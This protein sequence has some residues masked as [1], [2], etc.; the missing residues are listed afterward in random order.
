LKGAKEAIKTVS[1][2]INTADRDSIL[3]NLL[4]PTLYKAISDSLSSLPDSN[5][6]HLHLDKVKD[7]RLVSINSIT[8][9]VPDPDDRH[10]VAW[11]GQ[12]I[13]ASK[14]KLD[15]IVSS[16]NQF[17]VYTAKE[18]GK[19]AA[20]TK[21]LFILSVSFKAKEKFVITETETGNIVQG[22]DQ[23][24]NV[25]H[26]WQFGSEVSHHESYPF[27]WRVYDINRYLEST[28]PSFYY[29]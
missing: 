18:L 23:Y 11:L 17:T 9:T 4:H 16:N 26:I 8:G 21:I 19:E 15:N 6:I 14:T 20:L 22:V 24:K 5:N 1:E 7:M 28:N 10:V 25:H 27:H 13:I 3:G 12:K 29:H 2:L